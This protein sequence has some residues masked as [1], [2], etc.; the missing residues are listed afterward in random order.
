MRIGFAKVD[1]TPR[2]GV[3][4]CGFGPFLNRGSIGIRDRLWVRAMAVEHDGRRA[5][6]VSCDLLGLSLPTTTAAR[7]RVRT[8]LG[9][10]PHEV[11]ITCTHTHSGPDTLPDLIGWGGSDPPYMELLPRRLAAAI[12]QAVADLGEARMLHAEVPCE[13]IGLNREQD[14]DAPPIEEVLRD[15]WRPARPELTD[16]T[17]HVLSVIRDGCLRGFVS[18]FSCHPVVCCQ[19]CRFIHGDY[20]GVATNMLEREHP[21]SVGLFL[22]G[23]NGDINSC[24]VHKPEQ[25][26]LLALDV[27]A[28]RYA[29]A[30]RRGLA[31]GDPVDVPAMSTALHEVDFARRPWDA[32]AVRNRLSAE[33]ALI[34]DHSATDADPAYRL[35]V[36]R[37]LGLRRV[38]KHIEAGQAPPPVQLQGLRLGPV[39]L[40]ASPFETFRRIKTDVQTAARSPVA[41]VVSLANDS[42]GYAPDRLASE[43]GGYAADQVPLM[44]GL[45]PFARLHEQLPAALLKVEAALLQGQR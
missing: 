43:R 28:A 27:I 7:E 34:A 24:V 41:L 20:A 37:M 19:Q 33:L 17:C 21:G 42:Q 4:L 40:L 29:N 26:S 31:A 22:Q 30:V 36:V 14:R 9:L 38:L 32:S 2:V 15:Q 35:A 13:G 18:Y 16:T 6:L 45:T 11:M 5:V 12:E 8:S 44:Y 10:E 23:A 1:I 3:P 39:A 25:E